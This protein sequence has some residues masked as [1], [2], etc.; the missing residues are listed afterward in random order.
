MSGSTLLE[1]ARVLTPFEVLREPVLLRDGRIEAVGADA[2]R[3][4]AAIRLDLRGDWLAPGFIDL[5][6]HGGGGAQF[7]GASV[8]QCLEAARFHVAHGTT[9]LLATT[10]AAPLEAL[11]AAVRTVGAAAEA[12]DGDGATLL[13][14]HL[15]GPFLNPERHGAMNPK[16]MRLPDVA[17]LR[18]LIDAGGGY[19]RM[20]AVAAELPGALELIRYAADAGLVVGVGH[21]DASYEE[22][23]AAFDA[24]A[25]HAIHLF[26]AM[27]PF[28]HRQPGVIAAALERGSVSCE[29]IA[30]G[31]H[32]HPAAL[33]LAVALKGPNQAVLITDAME[34]AGMPDGSYRLGEAEIEVIGGRA[35]L[36]DGSSLAG[37][38]LTMDAAVRGLIEMIGASLPDAVTMAT[39]T[40]AH[41]LGIAEE[42]G[43]IA[44]GQRADLVVLDD[45]L[46][47]LAT[48]RAGRFVHGSADR[49]R[50]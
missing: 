25:S 16:W 17:E 14:C 15:E 33:R 46:Q 43:R 49:W 44:P 4:P 31:H 6:V 35:L 36:A 26:N 24:G 29:L 34:A 13:G 42:I 50:V 22:A 28:H 18:A 9:A 41:V 2:R 1:N 3:D 20:V 45:K 7:T 38:T 11:I 10:V 40:P 47:V 19:V 39:A 8:Q 37:S 23:N 32:L 27:R 12:D 30:D 48:V 21:S 5:H